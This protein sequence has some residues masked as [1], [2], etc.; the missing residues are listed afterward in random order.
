[1]TV[2]EFMRL[3]DIITNPTT[4]GSELTPTFGSTTPDV[5]SDSITYDLFSSNTYPAGVV[6]ASKHSSIYVAIYKLNCKTLLRFK[7]FPR[8]ESLDVSISPL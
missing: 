2:K 4:A 8:V 1:M 7:N 6:H 5:F 3:S